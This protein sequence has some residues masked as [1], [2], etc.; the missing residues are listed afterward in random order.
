MELLRDGN[1]VKR[2]QLSAQTH[3]ESLLTEFQKTDRL[4]QQSDEDQIRYDTEPKAER[5]LQP[6]PTNALWDGGLFISLK[7]AEGP[8]VVDSSYVASQ[9]LDPVQKRKPTTGNVENFLQ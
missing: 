8:H 3:N 1:H 9:P 6:I 5:I 4:V 7:A 2:V